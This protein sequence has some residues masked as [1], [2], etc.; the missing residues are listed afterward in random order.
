MNHYPPRP[1]RGT[2]AFASALLAYSLMACSVSGVTGGKRETKGERT[3][4]E[5][6]QASAP[7]TKAST[8]TYYVEIRSASSMVL[9]GGPAVLEIMS[10]F[11]IRFPEFNLKCQGFDLNL[12]AMLGSA[13]QTPGT[14]P[15]PEKLLVHDG[16]LLLM[17]E[18]A[19]AKFN[20]P[21]PFILGPVIQNPEKYRG[22]SRS[23]PSTVTGKNPS[24]G[25][26]ISANGSFDVTVINPKT[27][28]SYPEKSIKLDNVIHWKITKSGF[29]DVPATMGL[30]FSEM[31]WYYSYLP[32]LI[33]MIKIKGQI[34]DF[35]T[36]AAGNTSN[37]TLAND[38][39]G[40]LTTTL[41]LQKFE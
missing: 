27:D 21:R 37:Q 35:I 32:I 13:M 39:V 36:P 31:E 5:A 20:P 9:C 14:T 3:P 12:A 16:F 40:Q 22:F 26:T 23:Y 33:P 41:T 11:Q 25:K 19:G 6:T 38:M 34:S 8:S 28:Y 24:T 1:R 10:N 30:L 7:A 2:Y 4:A 18:L 17:E 29:N 15:T